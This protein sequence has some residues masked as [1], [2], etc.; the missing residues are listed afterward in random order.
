MDDATQTNV[1]FERIRPLKTNKK[2]KQQSKKRKAIAITS[3][4]SDEADDADEEQVEEE[5]VEAPIA[6]K[7]KSKAAMPKK[8]QTKNASPPKKKGRKYGNIGYVPDS[9]ELQLA[10]KMGL[11]EGWAVNVKPNS[12]FT[13]RSPDGDMRFTSKKAVFEHLGLPLPKHGQ[14]L[15]SDDDND[16]YDDDSDDVKVTTKSTKNNEGKDPMPIEDGDPPWRTSGHKYL[17]RRVEYNFPDGVVG[18]G[19]CTGWISEMD[20][21][22][23]NNPGFV[24]ERTNEPAC[25]FHVTMD[26]DCPVASQDFEG[27]EMED[28]MVDEEE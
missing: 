2:K 22:K 5:I 6:A 18:N 9:T 13:F 17:G 7:S 14:N 3:T 26:S 10:A 20:V 16:D 15:F 4:S 19:T 24:S 12:K 1:C 11:P 23:D 8:A 28:I 21:D 25:L 27:Y